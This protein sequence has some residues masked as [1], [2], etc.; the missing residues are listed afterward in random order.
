MFN[1]LLF[2]EVLSINLLASTNNTVNKSVFYVVWKNDD[3]RKKWTEM[4]VED[5]IP[6]IYTSALVQYDESDPAWYY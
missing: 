3:W 1:S 6:Q 5:Y 4:I 2:N